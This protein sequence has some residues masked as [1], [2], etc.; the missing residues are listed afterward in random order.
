MLIMYNVT[1]NYIHLYVRPPF[2]N[3]WYPCV[4]GVGVCFSCILHLS[5][6]NANHLSI[7]IN[8]KLHKFCFYS[9]IVSSSHLLQPSKTP[10]IS[11]VDF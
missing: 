8:L 9:V 7:Q 6:E 5:I 10:I 4:V 1:S 3:H 11:I 2:F